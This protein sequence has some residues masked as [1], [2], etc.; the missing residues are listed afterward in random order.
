MTL[1]FGKKKLPDGTVVIEPETMERK[2]R[3]PNDFAASAPGGGIRAVVRRNAE[4]IAISMDTTRR[5]GATYS[6]SE[7]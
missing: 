1:G 6:S 5:G 2:F 7:S 4:K 3:F